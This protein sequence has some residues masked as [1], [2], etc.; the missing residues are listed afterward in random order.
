MNIELRRGRRSPGFRKDHLT[1][2]GVRFASIERFYPT[3]ANPDSKYPY[4]SMYWWSNISNE[5]GIRIMADS[6]LKLREEFNFPTDTN[7]FAHQV[8]DESGGEITEPVVVQVHGNNELQEF[9]FKEETPGENLGDALLASPLVPRDFDQFLM[10]S[11]WG[12]Y[13]LEGG[14]KLGRYYGLVSSHRVSGELARLYSLTGKFT[15]N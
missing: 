2:D 9:Y 1:H 6:Y 7:N 10:D 13:C 5:E 12:S 4:F 8:L 15:T 3:P 11:P 14:G